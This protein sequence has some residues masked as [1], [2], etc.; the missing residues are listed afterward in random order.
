MTIRMMDQEPLLTSSALPVVSLHELKFQSCQLQVQINLDHNWHLAS[1]R[2]RR[3]QW[4]VNTETINS[5][6]WKSQTSNAFEECCKI[7]Q[8]HMGEYNGQNNH[9]RLVCGALNHWDHYGI[10]LLLLI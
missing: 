6:K 4:Y 7:L 5:N 9:R 8:K 1:K 2:E 3:K 10:F